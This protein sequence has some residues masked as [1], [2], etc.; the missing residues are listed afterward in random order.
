MEIFRSDHYGEKLPDP[1]GFEGVNLQTLQLRKNLKFS[2]KVSDK[3]IENYFVNFDK[4]LKE[5]EMLREKIIKEKLFQTQILLPDKSQVKKEEFMKDKSKENIEKKEDDEN[6]KNAKNIEKNQNIES[7][8]QKKV[9][10]PP[11]LLF[12]SPQNVFRNDLISPRFKDTKIIEENSIIKS[13]KLQEHEKTAIKPIFSNNEPKKHFTEE[14]KLV[15]KKQESINKKETIKDNLMNQESKNLESNSIFT[16]NNIKSLNSA[17]SSI[18]ESKNGSFSNNFPPN[19][20]KN[21]SKQEYQNNSPKISELSTQSLSK[22]LKRS[23]KKESEKDQIGKLKNSN[24]I[25]SHFEKSRLN[26]KNFL[27]N[28]NNM[29]YEELIKL[30]ADKFDKGN[31]FSENELS[32][33]EIIP[34]SFEIPEKSCT[35]CQESYKLNDTLSILNCLHIYHY[36]CI[37]NWLSRKKRCPIGCHL[38]FIN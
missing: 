35:I 13:Q 18:K 15:S 10:L 5:S 14:T 7:C 4:N 32:N 6:A 36:E 28:E 37:C 34:Y 8:Q 2:D 12:S 26:S 17:T 1:H 19:F 30:D 27:I 25:G 23:E 20:N 31:G 24:Q 11:L 33:L 21:P 22:S 16:K 3:F 38:V 29:T 9:I